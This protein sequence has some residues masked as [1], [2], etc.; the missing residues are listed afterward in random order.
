MS[1]AAFVMAKKGKHIVTSTIEHS[2]VLKS[3]RM[4]E[5]MG[6]RATKS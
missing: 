2:A 3:L 1:G 6:Y 5:R 4:L